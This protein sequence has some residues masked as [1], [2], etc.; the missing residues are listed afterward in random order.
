MTSCELQVSRRSADAAARKNSSGGV[1]E[2]QSDDAALR[3]WCGGRRGIANQGD[4]KPRSAVPFRS[5]GQ[6]R[7]RASARTPNSKPSSASPVCL[8]SLGVSSYER[9][10][11]GGPSSVSHNSFLCLAPR[12]MQIRRI[13]A[14]RL[15]F[16]RLLVV[17]AHLLTI[18]TPFFLTRVPR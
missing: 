4:A 2:A 5:D 12:T 17:V 15:A 10:A 14:D 1:E 11:P 13:A 18:W 9:I 7:R 6:G 8:F 16:D 3:A